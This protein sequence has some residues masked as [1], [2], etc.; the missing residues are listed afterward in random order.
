MAAV[1]REKIAAQLVFHEGLVLAAYLCPTGHLT[2]GVGH[3]LE[4]D[5]ALDVL[6]RRIANVG[7]SI[8][9]EEAK[10][11]LQRDLDRCVVELNGFAWFTAL[12]QPRQHVLV[13][14]VFNLGMSRFRAFKNMLLALERGD[15][16]RAAGEMAD[17][18][19]AQQVPQRAARLVR[20]MSENVA[21]EQIVGVDSL[22]RTT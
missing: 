10:R 9:A 22:P 3:N 8:N 21:F 11:L 18:R 16:R 12:T 1:D 19:W 6:G 7:E 2:V 4:A 17:S 5:P 13:D 15:F 20:M 14:M